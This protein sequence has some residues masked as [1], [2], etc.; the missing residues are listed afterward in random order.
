MGQKP[1]VRA[2]LRTTIGFTFGLRAIGMIRGLVLARLLGPMTFDLFVPSVA[3]TSLVGLIAEL[4]LTPYVVFRG[5]RARHDAAAVA[6][7]SLASGL[8]GAA[9]VALLASP[10]AEF[11]GR[12]DAR[13]I[14]LALAAGVPL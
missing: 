9:A 1:S 13:W 4:G 7:F 14:A 8:V 3:F 5:D 10:I 6:T 12:S 11:Y 2:A